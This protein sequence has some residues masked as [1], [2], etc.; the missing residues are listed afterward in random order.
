MLYAVICYRFIPSQEDREEKKGA[1][2]LRKMMLKPV[3]H[4]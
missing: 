4:I 3:K 2:N 1:V